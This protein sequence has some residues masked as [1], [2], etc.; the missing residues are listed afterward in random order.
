MPHARALRPQHTLR[1]PYENWRSPLR[2]FPELLTLGR[3]SLRKV[4]SLKKHR[5]AGAYE[6]CYIERGSVMWWVGKNIYEVK[7]GDIFVTWPGELHGGIDDVLHPCKVYWIEFDFPK[8]YRRDWLG[9]PPQEGKS[10][11]EGLKHLPRRK[12]SGP[13]S[14]ARMLDGVFDALNRPSRLT[15]PLVRAG[16]LGLLA[17]VIQSSQ[18][19]KSSTPI[20]SSVYAAIERMDKNLEM[21]LPL[22]EIAA[23]IGWSISH[24]KRQFRVELGVPPGEFYLRRRLAAA[25]QRIEH[26]GAS[27]A[28]VAACFGFSSSQYLATCFRRVTGRTPSSFRRVDP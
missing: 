1:I 5:H 10:I 15:A 8:A 4:T 11:Y 27:L 9:V 24:F 28:S 21:P 13:D 12:F 14:L 20:S 22:P 25:R 18:E 19:A 6:I 26:D 7:G 23:Q 2:E 17:Q 16:L 3:D